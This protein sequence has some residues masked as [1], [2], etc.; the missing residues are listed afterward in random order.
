M[1]TAHPSE[2]EKFNLLMMNPVGHCHQQIS[3]IEIA[4]RNGSIA[5]VQQTLINQFS[6]ERYKVEIIGKALVIVC[7]NNDTEAVRGLLDAIPTS[8]KLEVLTE[9]KSTD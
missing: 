1:A 2:D 9:Y 6:K 4:S 7:Q 8:R 5:W 3:A